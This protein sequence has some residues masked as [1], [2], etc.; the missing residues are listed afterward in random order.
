MWRLDGVADVPA[1]AKSEA[2]GVGG[3]SAVADGGAAVEAIVAS[4]RC[5]VMSDGAAA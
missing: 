5:G 2:A 4:N 3:A 1:V